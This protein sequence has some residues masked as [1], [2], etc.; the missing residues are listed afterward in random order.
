MLENAVCPKCKLKTI[1][2]L[3]VLTSGH[4]IGACLYCDLPQEDD[5]FHIY[6]NH[7]W[8]CGYGIDSRFNRPSPIEGMGY[9]CNYCGKD[10]LEWKLGKGLITIQQ[11]LMLKG[12]QLC[13]TA[14]GV[15]TST[16][17]L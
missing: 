14:T 3:E 12:A 11:L 8:N 4:I 16:G 17:M 5:H 13:C 6:E 7:C 1:V 15:P 9:I 10:L 2:P